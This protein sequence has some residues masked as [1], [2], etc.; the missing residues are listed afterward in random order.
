MARLVN[1]QT[2]GGEFITPTH[3]RGIFNSRKY[4][5]FKNIMVLAKVD[6]AGGDFSID[7]KVSVETSVANFWSPLRTVAIPDNIDDPSY[8]IIREVPVR[9][10]DLEGHR[11]IYE[12]ANVDRAFQIDLEFAGNDD[13]KVT[14]EAADA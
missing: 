9:I 7:I 8:A 4:T 11:L 13:L 1:S 6:E 14:V 5:D 2:M 10:T 12:V 3:W